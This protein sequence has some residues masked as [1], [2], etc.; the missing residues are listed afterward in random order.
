MSLE[1]PD[2]RR[3]L[4]LVDVIDECP[5]CARH[6]PIV[7]SPHRIMAQRLAYQRQ[8]SQGAYS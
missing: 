1:D 4:L 2:H 3:E 8:D 5:Y 7:C 6:F